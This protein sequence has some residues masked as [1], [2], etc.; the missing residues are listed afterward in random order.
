MTVGQSCCFG[1]VMRLDVIAEVR[2]RV[3]TAHL[4]LGNR[5]EWRRKELGSCY[6][7]LKHRTNRSNSS[8]YH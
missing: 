3:K 6:S 4:K 8:L 5:K 7:P 2:G 1:S